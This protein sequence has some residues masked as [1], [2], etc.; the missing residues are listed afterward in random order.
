M[1]R[2]VL[3]LL[4][5]Y[6]NLDKLDSRLEFRVVDAISLFEDYQDDELQTAIKPLIETRPPLMTEALKRQDALI[7]DYWSAISY[8]QSNQDQS[9]EIIARW[10]RLENQSIFSRPYLEIGQHY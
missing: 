8:A 9:N 3:N 5:D 4:Q 6:R 2:H 1:I 7:R 10:K